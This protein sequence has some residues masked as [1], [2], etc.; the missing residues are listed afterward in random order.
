M[1]TQTDII[2]DLNDHSNARESRNVIHIPGEAGM[3][4][5][6]F[7]EGAPLEWKLDTGAINTFITED[8]Y[9]SILPEQRP[10]LEFAKKRFQAADGNNLRV[11]GTAKMLISF[12]GFSVIFRVFVGGVKTNLLGLDFITKFRCQWNFDNNSCVLN[13]A[14]DISLQGSH[15]FSVEDCVIPPHHEAIIKA[16]GYSGIGGGEGILVPLQN[17]V[18]SHGLAVAR[19]VVNLDAKGNCIFLRVFNP[20]E[21]EV[22][23]KENTA[24]AFIEPVECV[25]SPVNVTED[26]S[27]VDVTNRK[28]PGFL[29]QVFIGGCEHLTDEQTKKFKEFLLSRVEAFA[30]PSKPAERAR[31][32]EHVIKLKEEIPFKEAVRRVPI[33][34]REV[35]DNEITKLE[36]QGLIEKSESP[37]S[38]PLVLVQ[39]KDKSW[40]LCVDYRKLNANTIKDAYPIPRVADDLDSL[41]GSAWFSS[42]DLNMAYHQIPMHKADKEKTAFATPRGGLY[43]YT[44]MPFGLCNAPATFQR[45]IEKVLSGLQW[46]I[47]VLYLDDIIVH[48]RDFDTHLENLNLVLDRL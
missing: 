13:C 28:L 2:E 30:D 3:K 17:F 12:N 6:G 27:S 24:V 47:S 39:K 11:I 1:A 18:L 19:V 4:L 32:G 8:A 14:S 37:W 31:V 33:F 15:V 29:E 43:Q 40:R 23:V 26:V 9:Y 38:S 44:V 7:I 22:R 34:K 36:E 45:V 42:L 48:S 20:F 10:V 21:E 46:R 5:K 35:L 16:R 25:S 41:A